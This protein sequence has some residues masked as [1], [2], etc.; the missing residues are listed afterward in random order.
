VIDGAVV[1]ISAP[2]RTDQPFS[3]QAHFRLP[4]GTITVLK[5]KKRGYAHDLDRWRS[6]G[7]PVLRE[8][9]V[10]RRVERPYLGRTL[11]LAQVS[12]PSILG[13]T[14][15]FVL[16]VWEG[17][18]GSIVASRRGDDLDAFLNVLTK[19]PF[20]D[21]PNGS[22]VALRALGEPR[23]PVALQLL[24]GIGLL[25]VRPLIPAVT[26]NLPAARG[27]RVAGGEL[28]RVREDRNAVLLVTDSAAVTIEMETQAEATQ[29]PQPES[30]SR[31]EAEAEAVLDHLSEIHV[32]WRV[33]P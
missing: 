9:A 25:V 12:R 19:V 16:A 14:K 21:G 1:E 31:R 33:R 17:R 18:Y 29:E 7:D 2:V 22:T 4:D 6:H 24:P 8:F 27:A 23:P 13:K 32:G 15:R 30:T 10:G 3:S 28:F 20:R 5:T 26:R 11:H